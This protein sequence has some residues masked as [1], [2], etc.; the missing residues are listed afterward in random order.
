MG[1][2]RMSVF[3]FQSKRGGGGG[4]SPAWTKQADLGQYVVADYYQMNMLKSWR[5]YNIFIL[6][7]F[8]GILLSICYFCTRESVNLQYVQV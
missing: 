7:T 4:V 1:P 5:Y 6:Q 8:F 3:F 2:L